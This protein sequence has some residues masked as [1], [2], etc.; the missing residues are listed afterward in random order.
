M[1]VKYIKPKGTAD[2]MPKDSGALNNLEKKLRDIVGLYGYEEIRL[3]T[4]ESTEVFARGVG[5]TT[6]IVG[7]EMYT[8]IDKGG[9]SITLRPEGTAGVARAVL[10]N[11]LL[12]SAPSPLKMY[13][14]QSC[15][16]YEKMQKGRLRE[17]H[18]LGIECFGAGAPTSD[19]EVISV[20]A[21]ILKK[22]GL[23]GISLEINS[24][25]CTECRPNYHA[26]LKEY[27]SKYKDQLCGT[28]IERLER[29]PMRI[30]DCKCDACKKI[31][32]DAPLA[33]NFLC[34]NCNTHFNAVKEGLNNLEIKYTVNP[35]IVR[36]LDYYSNTV[37]EF[38]H[39]GVGTQ[40]TVCGGGRYNGLISE[41]EG[42]ETPAVGFGM[43]I[44]RLLLALADEG[45]IL[46]SSSPPSLYIASL[47]V[48]G[49]K[50]ACV[51]AN[52]LRMNGLYVEYDIVGRGLKAQMKYADKLSAKFSC[53]LGDNEVDEKKATLKNMQTGETKEV[54]LSVQQL[55]NA[56]KE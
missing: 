23:K 51:L 13:Y 53:V 33:I 25:G 29:N 28:C 34:H 19:V 4:F 37:F 41:F 30:L 20:A 56:V 48:N 11:G 9:R 40:G 47:G 55:L 43:G 3:P 22:L 52:K 16:R 31:A 49:Q 42:P 14:L 1:A 7:K 6:D 2:I 39:T 27:F 12:G 17:F 18:Q 35:T 44:E 8:F 38:I 24:I 32:A 50:T 46:E 21:Q 54:E 5:D 36:G 15:F 26:A 10:E 45:I